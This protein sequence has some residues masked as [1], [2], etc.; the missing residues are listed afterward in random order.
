MKSEAMILTPGELQRIR[1]YVQHKY[2]G[3]P[4]RQPEIFADAIRRVVL[5]ELPEL[6]PRQRETIASS[7]IRQQVLGERR[8]VRAED[9]WRACL[10]ELAEPGEQEV[11]ALHRW[12][13]RRL[14]TT[15]PEGRLRQLIAGYGEAPEACRWSDVMAEAKQAALESAAS[16][17]ADIAEQTTRHRPWL[18]LLGY[19]ILSV[20]VVASTLL[21]VRL[22]AP[23]AVLRELPEALKLRTPLV[24]HYEP[25]LPQ[26][27]VNELPDELRY[28]AIDEA[29]LQAYLAGRK[30]LL[31]DEPYY[32]AMMSTAWRYD[33]HPL[34]LFAIAGQE[35]GFVPRDHPEAERIVNNPFNV[36]YSWQRYNTTIDDSAEI[37]ARTVLRWA[38][39]RPPG[40]EALAWIN[41]KYAED[42]AWSTGVRRLFEAMTAAQP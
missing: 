4:Q 17:T 6:P 33:I 29:A 14:G 31:A 7:L 37:A 5:R 39:D 12:L 25:A 24:F 27:I 35:Q 1:S 41:R 30:S 8:P 38:R 9:I 32:S 28:A 19:A 22:T 40:T 10:A 13:E 26:G 23:A 11:Q 20:A 18:A 36:Y 21:Y 15:L 2:A 3:S 16:Q 34:L 42:P